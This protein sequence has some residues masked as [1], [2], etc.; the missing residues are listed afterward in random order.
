MRDQSLLRA[1]LSPLTGHA[2]YNWIVEILPNVAC[3]TTLAVVFDMSDSCAGISEAAER[4]GKW[5]KPLPRDLAIWVYRISSGLPLDSGSDTV[6]HL[7]DGSLTPTRWFEDRRLRELAAI[8]G[9]F[10]APVMTAIHA[11]ANGAQ[12]QKYQVLV[13]TD[14]ELLDGQEIPLPPGCEVIGLTNIVDQAKVQLW[15]RVLPRSAFCTMG[16]RVSDEWLASAQ[17]SQPGPCILSL[18]DKRRSLPL[19][20]WD[21][22]SRRISPVMSDI[23]W[24]CFERPLLLLVGEAESE[25]AKLAWHCR[26]VQ[27][28]ITELIRVGPESEAV[29]HSQLKAIECSTQNDR[30]TSANVLIDSRTGG[31]EFEELWRDALH[32]Q[33]MTLKRLPWTD[34]AGM[35]LAFRSKAALSAMCDDS[36]HLVHDGLLCLILGP[37]EGVPN[38]ESRLVIIALRRQDRPALFWDQHNGPSCGE[39]RQSLSIVFDRMERRW[40]VTIGSDPAVVVSPRGSLA[41]G[42]PAVYSGDRPWSVLFFGRI[43]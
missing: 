28:N 34:D 41:L 42:A 37:T 19:A 4:L 13:L 26:F 1:R 15:R 33:D 39:V 23:Q 18:Q 7:Q 38:Q 29:D 21:S 12:F 31:S 14:G 27:R 24:N 6:G 25:I 20:I 16:D 40:I 10:L 2:P 3:S 22:E 5:L 30:G 9:S 8:Q 36:G 11:R 35:L 43:A 17:K 32:A